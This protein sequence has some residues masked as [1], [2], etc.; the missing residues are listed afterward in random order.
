M[1]ISSRRLRPA[2]LL[3]AALLSFSL[4]AHAQNFSFLDDE[5]ESGGFDITATANKLPVEWSLNQQENGDGYRLRLTPTTAELS[6]QSG[7]KSTPLALVKTAVATGAIVIQRRGPRWM[8]LAGNRIILQAEDDKWLEGKVGYRGGEIK[9]PRLQPVEEITFDDDFMRVAKEVAFTAAFKANPATGLNIKTAEKGAETIWLPVAGTWAT[10]GVS[11]QEQA[12]VAQSANPFGFVAK[13]KGRNLALAGR[14]FWS[15]YSVE[16][17]IKPQNSTSVGLAIYVQDAQNYLLF[18]WQKNGAFSISA[19]VKGVSKVLASS[20]NDGF[21]ERNWYRLKFAVSAGT[22]RAFVDDNEVLRTRVDQFGRGQVGLLAN[23]LEESTDAVEN[24]IFDD[25][26]V[27]SVDDFYDDFS[28]PVAGRWQSVAGT[29]KMASAA[30]PADATGAFTVMGESEWS[31]YT[32]SADISLPAD[33]VAGLVT[34]HL[35]GQGAYI[36]RVAASQSKLPYAGKA[37]ILKIGAGKGTILSEV[38]VGKRFDNTNGRWSFGVEKGY[39]QGTIEIDGKAVRVLDAWNESNGGGRAGLYAQKGAKG[40]P[41]LK[42]FAVEFPRQNSRW[43]PVPDIYVDPLQAQTMGAW[44]TPEGLWMPTNPLKVNTPVAVVAGAAKPPETKTFWHKG[45]FW[46]D[47][48]IRFKLPAMKSDQSLTLILGNETLKA[49]RST[50]PLVLVLKTDGTNLMAALTRGTDQKLKDATKKI[51][52]A[53]ENQPIEIS[54]RGNFVIV[55]VG[56]EDSQST[57]LAAKI[58][59]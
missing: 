39:L 41:V 42:N 18:E 55:R 28:V 19:V 13:S 9:E 6:I 43:A 21:D 20:R 45:A 48:D 27:R 26:R 51:E 34:H 17:S 24:A 53:L 44:S 37:Q 23:N 4:S 52:G 30:T 3:L 49:T 46:G 7:G 58:A 1:K 25:L 59:G 15:D 16:A 35:K 50:P 57:L 8:V 10:T 12:M 54:R 29:W 33:A 32:T 47:Q 36:F 38:S 31:D 22:L 40:V 14:P 11:E 2:T 56:D 5:A